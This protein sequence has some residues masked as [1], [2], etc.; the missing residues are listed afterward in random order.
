MTLPAGASPT[1][2]GAAKPHRSRWAE[3]FSVEHHPRYVISDPEVR[4]RYQRRRLLL[5]V[6][7]GALGGVGVGFTLSHGGLIGT[8]LTTAAIIPVLLGIAIAITF[9][10]VPLPKIM[11]WIATVAVV[12][13]CIAA[14]D[15]KL[16]LQIGLAI[17]GFALSWIVAVLLQFGIGVTR[18]TAKDFI[19]SLSGVLLLGM[20]LALGSSLAATPAG[21]QTLAGGL[22]PAGRLLVEIDG[23]ASAFASDGTG[24]PLTI[25]IDR[26]VRQ[27]Q[28]AVSAASDLQRGT[29]TVELIDIEPFPF[30]PTRPVTVWNADLQPA[31]SGGSTG[32][33]EVVITRSSQGEGLQIRADAHGA[34]LGLVAGLGHYR[35]T[36]TDPESGVTCTLDGFL[37]ITAS[38]LDTAPGRAG[39]V[40]AIAGLG[41]AGGALAGGSVRETK[42]LGRLA[43][44]TA[45]IS[46]QRV[47]SSGNGSGGEAEFDMIL[48]LQASE[49]DDD[50]YRVEQQ[51]LGRLVDMVH[52]GVAAALSG[53]GPWEIPIQVR[54]D[55]KKVTA[56]WASFQ[57]N[58]VG[59]SASAAPMVYSVSLPV[60]SWKWRVD[61]LGAGSAEIDLRDLAEFP[62][63]PSPDPPPPPSSDLPPPPF[64]ALPPP[65]S[66]QPAPL[67]P[68]PPSADTPPPPKPP[69]TQPSPPAPPA[70]APPDSSTGTRR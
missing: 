32:P 36:L 17:I 20:A 37:R 52:I 3:L 54:T 45:A 18:L 10:L 22:C 62:P 23:T 69:P 65:P 67:V 14:M 19:T 9:V 34:D 24:D 56:D 33:S 63:P 11:R 58:L 26:D 55:P 8:G 59:Q 25:N 15:M 46:T 16:E 44:P 39:L 5:A 50:V 38:P 1:A 66:L 30:L 48:Q 60:N 57:I 28:F 41:L 61:M 27:T 70:W 35:A 43:L 21:A 7:G 51:G 12:V 42:P 53:Q 40:A 13:V 64:P 2:A 68:P 47:L 49:D 4:R 6:V 29:V 31:A